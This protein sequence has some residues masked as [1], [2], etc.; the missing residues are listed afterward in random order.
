MT[1]VGV[2]GAGRMGR[3]MAAAIEAATGDPVLVCSG[4]RGATATLEPILTTCAP[5]VLAVPF[6]VAVAVLAAG[7]GARGGGRTLI[8]A[9]NPASVPPPW[10]S[11]GE[12]IAA[13]AP[14]W[15]VAKAFNT[16][17]ADQLTASHMDGEPLTLPV[18]GVPAARA[19][20]AGLA[21]RLGF[22]PLDAGGI[23]GSCELESL[24]RLL[25]RVSGAHGLHGRVGIRVG[26]PQRPP[27]TCER[28]P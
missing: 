20:A 11:G 12:M 6:P 16:V 26:T 23:E 15:R 8:D 5:V 25:M 2:I 19:E 3:A 14:A 7:A 13:L 10:P 24:A 18:A 28:T 21:R 27:V 17:A 9:T 22:A 4:R 1:G